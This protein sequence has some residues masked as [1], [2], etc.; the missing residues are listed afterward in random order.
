MELKTF[1]IDALP[2]YDNEE[3][4]EIV[5]KY[6]LKIKSLC[7]DFVADCSEKNIEVSSADGWMLWGIFRGLTNAR[8][9]LYV[10]KIKDGSITDDT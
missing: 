2:G 6:E 8:F 4:Q 7:E 9:D 10:K 1:T 3:L 5:N